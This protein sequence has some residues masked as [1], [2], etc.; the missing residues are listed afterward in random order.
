MQMLLRTLLEGSELKVM[1][2][3]RTSS[4]IVVA[5]PINSTIYGPTRVAD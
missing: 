4:V 2:D 1:S 5:S 3:S